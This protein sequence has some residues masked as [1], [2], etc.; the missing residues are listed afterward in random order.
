MSSKLSLLALMVIVYMEVIGYIVMPKIHWI[1]QVH[2]G[3]EDF[4]HVNVRLESVYN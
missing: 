3:K 4:P 1:D 2:T